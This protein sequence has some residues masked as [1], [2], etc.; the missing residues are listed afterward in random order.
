[1]RASTRAYTT[2]DDDSPA[3]STTTATARFRFLSKPEMKAKKIK[4]PNMA[5]VVMMLQQEV[6]IYDY[7]DYDD[8]EPSN[9]NEGWA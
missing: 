2:D 1:M 5:D 8:S 7:D 4:S 9:D 3:E 6:D